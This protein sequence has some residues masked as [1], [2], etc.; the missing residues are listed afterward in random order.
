MHSHQQSQQ[1]IRRTLKVTVHVGSYKNL[2]AMHATVG[3]GSKTPLYV[4]ANGPTLRMFRIG[5]A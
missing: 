5:H 2:N 4:L 1:S 3:I